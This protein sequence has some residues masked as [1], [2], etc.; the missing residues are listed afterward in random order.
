MYFIM[1]NL[2]FLSLFVIVVALSSCDKLKD[3]AEELT[4][5]NFPIEQEISLKVLPESNLVSDKLKNK[6]LNIN[7]KD[8]LEGKTGDFAK[9]SVKDI[10]LLNFSFDFASAEEIEMDKEE[11]KKLKID[12]ENITSNDLEKLQTLETKSINN[13]DFLEKIQVIATNESGREI[14]L[15]SVEDI[16]KGKTIINL[17]V[18]ND[19]LDDYIKSDKLAI[20]MK[21]KSNKT[22]KNLKF[23][24]KMKF[25]LK[26]NLKK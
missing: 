11:L 19:F 10:K 17:K 24:M 13:F 14:T 15:G 26:L 6:E 5:T 4:K 25:E 23:N 9:N 2:K 21:Y 22:I 1:K 20:R 18:Y 16:E 3:I 8:K 7:L 12:P